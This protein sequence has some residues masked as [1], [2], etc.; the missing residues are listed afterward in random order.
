MNPHGNH[1]QKSLIATQKI[2]R[3]E[4]KNATTKKIIK[5]QRKRTREEKKN[6]WKG[7]RKQLNNENTIYH[8]NNNFKYKKIKLS[9]W[10][11]QNG[12]ISS[13]AQSCLTLQSHGLQ[14]RSLPCPSPIPR[15]NPNSC[16]LLQWC[17]PTISS[18][19]IPFS[20]HLQSF[21]A[22][23]P[24]PKNCFFQSGG[25]SIGVSASASC[26]PMNIQ[27][28]FPLRWTGWI[29]LQSKGLSRVFPNTTVQKHQYCYRLSCWYMAKP[30]QYCKIKK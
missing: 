20:C 26:L 21:P 25:Q 1:K 11:K 12:L 28:W 15:A 14:H 13:V 18:S 23:G 16:P 4:S 7:T 5:S 17:H 3:K 19:V 22:L 2:K 24:F 6:Y 30:I 9:S 27:D 8:V 10:K 29:S